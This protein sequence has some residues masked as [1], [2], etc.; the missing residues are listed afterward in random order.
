VLLKTSREV[1]N[2]KD[3]DKK[4]VLV[5]FSFPELV[6]SAVLVFKRKQAG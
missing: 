1:H 4:K 2:S 5:I 3:A 6:K